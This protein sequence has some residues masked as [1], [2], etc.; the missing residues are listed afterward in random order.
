M[1]VPNRGFT[2]VWTETLLKLKKIQKTV[3]AVGARITRAA[4]PSLRGLIVVCVGLIVVSASPAIRPL[5]SRFQGLIVVSQG[6]M[7]ICLKA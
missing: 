1:L 5:S 3:G 7:V 4:L 2:A 6:L